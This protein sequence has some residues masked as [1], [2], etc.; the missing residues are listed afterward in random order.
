VSPLSG[1]YPPPVSDPVVLVTDFGGEDTYA[2]ALIGAC[3][4]VDPGL[5]VATATHGVPPGD[6]LAG[7]HHLKAAALAFPRRS[8]FCA[9]VDPGVGSDRRA[10]AVDTGTVRCVAPD[11]GLL[12]YLWTEADAALRRCA[13]IAVPTAASPT[14]HGRDIFA[15][16]AAR[17]AAG[18]DLDDLGE[19]GAPPMLL[20]VAFARRDDAAL[21]GRVAAVDHFGNAI[22]TVRLADLG[23]ARLTGARWDGGGTDSVVRTYAEIGDGLAVLVGSAG[24]VEVAA[25]GRPGRCLGGPE[26]GAA[27]RVL[28]A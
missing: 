10:L 19:P 24:H 14:F 4:R 9:V 26:A 22:T 27:V 18:A 13:V 17:L 16:A 11:N 6:V 15:P 8:V 3:W 21:L 20:D 23:G 25:R 5:R 1:R 2:G 7:A 28:L 12:S